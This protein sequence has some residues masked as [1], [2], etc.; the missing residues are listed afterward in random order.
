MTDVVQKT[1]L[2]ATRIGNQFNAVL[3]QTGDIANLNTTATNLTSA[4]NE[5]RASIVALT[6]SNLVIND[7]SSNTSNV[8]SSSEIDARIAAGGVATQNSILGGVSTLFDTLEEIEAKFNSDDSVTGQILSAQALRVAVDSAQSF[9]A[10]Q[11]QQGRDNIGAAAQ[12]DL[13]NVSGADFVA[14]FE[15]ALA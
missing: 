5:N 15:A 10:A 7:G 6:T 14:T 11:Q 13:G 9:D 8:L 12:A 3:L 1:D 4:I 2:L